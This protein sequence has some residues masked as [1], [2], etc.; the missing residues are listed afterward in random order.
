V[1][2]EFDLESSKVAIRRVDLAPFFDMIRSGRYSVTATVKVPQWDQPFNSKPKS[3]DVLTGVKLWEQEFGVPNP[4]GEPKP[5]PEVR[6]YTLQ[7]ATHQKET[8]L[9]VRVSDVSESKVYR[10]FPLGPTLSFSKLN[11][12]LDKESNLHL[13]YQTGA[14]TYSYSVID[15][16][17]RV[18]VQQTHD[19]TASRP[20]L[21]TGPEG[22]ITVVGGTRRLDATDVPAP[23]NLIPS[24]VNP[25]PKP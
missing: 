22:N 9:Y 13:L 20:S 23:T 21:G 16:D 24:D 5:R 2:G 4:A 18:I 7:K 3:F 17:G 10:V 6:K 25:T 19:I 12:Q 1:A 11:P 8:K 15:P 14:R